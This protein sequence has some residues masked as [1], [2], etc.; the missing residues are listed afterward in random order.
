MGNEQ[1]DIVLAFAQ[2]GNVQGQDI[3]TEIEVAP[4]QAFAGHTEQVPV[5]GGN[6]P[7]VNVD[8]PV[9]AY[10]ENFFFLQGAQQAHLVGLGHF[11]Y[12]IQK[13]RAF[14]GHF[15][16]AGLAAFARAGKSALVVAEKLAFQQL[17]GQGGAVDG[18]KGPLFS[19]AAV[20]DALSQQL[21]ARAR[22]PFNQD[23][24]VA[25]GKAFGLGEHLRHFA[26]G[27]DN[28]AELVFGHQPFVRQLDARLHFRLLDFGQFLKG[29]D[30]F[31]V[32]VAHPDGH[33]VHH[34][35]FAAAGN[36]LVH[37]VVPVFKKHPDFR[38]GVRG[39]DVCAQH[40]STGE[41]EHLFGGKVADSHRV[42]AAHG[43][44]AADGIV[45]DVV[46]A[47]RPG[48]FLDVLFGDVAGGKHRLPD[49]L[50]TGAH[51]II[52]QAVFVSF[53]H[54]AAAKPDYAHVVGIIAQVFNNGIEF[55]AASVNDLMKR[56]LA[57]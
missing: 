18:H 23:R 33:A 57:A 56:A 27:A 55:R 10:P 17:F 46:Q 41:F 45:D 47:A 14:V 50:S 48:F 4:E 7:H 31:L 52:G 32:V 28:V 26:F 21:F 9:A 34:I 8:Y 40:L 35:G 6:N 24:G 30:G 1:W 29:D 12:F 19:V 3:K 51:Q 38:G 36:E 43:K 25:F 16:H 49:V 53:L 37:G 5:G 39:I 42:V 15:K 2:R 22:F 13:Q 54:H 44:D 11:A 20:V